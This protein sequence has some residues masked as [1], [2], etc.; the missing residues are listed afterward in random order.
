MVMWF[1]GK[2]KIADISHTF[3][4]AIESNYLLLNVHD[5]LNFLI[6]IPMPLIILPFNQILHLKPTVFLF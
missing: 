2:S 5:I 1:L 4:K 6:F 3:I